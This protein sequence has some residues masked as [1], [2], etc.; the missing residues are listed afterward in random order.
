M[1]EMEQQQQKTM[2]SLYVIFWLTCLSF[3]LFTSSFWL[4]YTWVVLSCKTFLRSYLKNVKTTHKIITLVTIC[5]CGELWLVKGWWWVTFLPT[6]TYHV[7]K[8]WSEL[9]FY[10]WS[11]TTHHTSYSHY[12][13]KTKQNC[14]SDTLNL[15]SPVVLFL[16]CLKYLMGNVN[17]HRAALVNVS[18]FAFY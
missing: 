9:W 2:I 1:K 18:C 14:I 13:N 11:S 5:P 15:I 6:T 17:Q 7:S 12:Q 16:Q 3:Y 10:V 8:L 4:V